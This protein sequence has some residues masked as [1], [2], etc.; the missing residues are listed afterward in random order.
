[1]EIT[2]LASGSGGNCTAVDVA[3][4]RLLIDAGISLK[5]LR[6][7]QFQAG[8]EPKI[9]SAVLVTHE[10]KDHVGHLADFCAYYQC[11]AYSDGSTQEAIFQASGV[12]C[13]DSCFLSAVP[14]MPPQVE[15][16]FLPAEHTSGV[17]GVQIDEGG[18]RMVLLTDCGFIP[19]GLQLAKRVKYL[20]IEADYDAALLPESGYD[21]FLQQRIKRDH[22]SNGQVRQLLASESF[23]RSRL[24]WV[25]LIHLSKHS[26]T[27]ERAEEIVRLSDVQCPVT[28]W[29]DEPIVLGRN[30]VL[31]KNL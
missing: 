28:A 15:V 27:P 16:S 7:L 12:R 14:W 30:V 20:L 31:Q 24:E 17:A 23:D 18:E 26:N 1:M 3:G 19:L 2:V 13:V 6:A 21:P 25:I 5:R 10:H 4:V 11:R 22:L 8:L 9:V 29:R